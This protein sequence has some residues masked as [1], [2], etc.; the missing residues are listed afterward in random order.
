[1]FHNQQFPKHFLKQ[2]YE[3]IY[4][5]D[6]LNFRLATLNTA[7]IHSNVQHLFKLMRTK[8]MR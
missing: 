1:M 4:G 5:Y 2:A 6:S 8:Y 3:R 7:L